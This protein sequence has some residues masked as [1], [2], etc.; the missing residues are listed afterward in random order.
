MHKAGFVNIVG[1]RMEKNTT[2]HSDALV[3]M[4]LYIYSPQPVAESPAVNVF[5]LLQ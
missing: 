4:N 1:H 3:L 5:P 2:E